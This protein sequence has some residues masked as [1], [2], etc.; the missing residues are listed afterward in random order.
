M[1]LAEPFGSNHGQRTQKGYA[2]LALLLCMALL[3]IAAAT[4]MQ[5][6]SFQIKRDREE[7]LIHRGVQYSRAIRSYAK[8][9]GRYPATLE[10]LQNTTETRFIRKLYKD[11]ITG[12][13]FRLLHQG[14]IAAP[15]GALPPSLSP[16]MGGDNQ[17]AVNGDASGDPPQNPA[18]ASQTTRPDLQTNPQ[19]GQPGPASN[20]SRYNQVGQVIFGVASKS[21]AKTIREFYRKN[22]YNEW[23]FFY[24]P[25]RDR[26]TEI[27]GPTSLA[28]VLSP[29]SGSS[30]QTPEQQQ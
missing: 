29:Q 17:N 7:E 14:D 4:V 5:S 21:R 24:D 30:G 2:L 19:N 23:L 11:P 6:I 22:H 28:P 10:Q 27:K 9:T 3:A 26:G 8:K 16:S 12:S 1:R 13:D 25:T 20:D 18:V 15:A